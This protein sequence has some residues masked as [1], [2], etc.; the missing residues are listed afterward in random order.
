MIDG[1]QESQERYRIA[2]MYHLLFLS[3]TRIYKEEADDQDQLVPG[4]DRRQAPLVYRE[5]CAKNFTEHC[6]PGTSTYE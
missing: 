6:C 2:A 3:H 4:N 1:A 5:G